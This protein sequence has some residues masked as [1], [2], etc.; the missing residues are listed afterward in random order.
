MKD[1]FPQCSFGRTHFQFGTQ[2]DFLASV[3]LD[4][5]TFLPECED[6]VVLEVGFAGIVIILFKSS[7]RRQMKI[8]MKS[9]TFY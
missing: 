3:L 1:H 5:L 8:R 9:V 7:L 4:S 6:C 2:N